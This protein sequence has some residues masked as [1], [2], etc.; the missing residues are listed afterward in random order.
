MDVVDPD[1][2]TSYSKL[3]GNEGTVVFPPVDSEDDD[4]DD[5][6]VEEDSSHYLYGTHFFL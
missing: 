4:D 1:Y 6:T 3:C 2:Y 5:T